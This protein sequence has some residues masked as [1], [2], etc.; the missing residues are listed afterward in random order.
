MRIDGLFE[1]KQAGKRFAPPRK[2]RIRIG[3]PLSFQATAE[4]AEVA[5]EL[6]KRVAE[7]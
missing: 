1:L 3:P 2:I 5:R 7:L 4:A 6:Q